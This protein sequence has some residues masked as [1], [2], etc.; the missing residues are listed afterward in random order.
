[1]RR[2]NLSIIIPVKNEEALLEKSI[3]QFRNYFSKQ[4]KI[5]KFEIILCENASEDNTLILCRKICRKLFNVSYIHA[6]KFGTAL[7][8]GILKAIFPYVYINGL[9]NPFKYEDLEQMLSLCAKFDLIYAS[10]THPQS[11]YRINLFR[12]TATLMHSFLSR[13]FFKLPFSD[14]QGTIFM[15]RRKILPL[16]AFCDSSGIFF[17]TQL[18]LQSMYHRLRITSV[19]VHY[20]GLTRRSKF[21]IIV[22]GIKYIF[23][24]F[25][26][27]CKISRIIIQHQY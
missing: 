15:E 17:Q 3:L 5:R 19:P 16:L 8:N 10:K 23:E 18:A 13:I 14:T 11:V 27:K 20:T 12:K 24:V 7:K 21:N 2:I 22:E 25:R 1:M 4:D 6:D 9:D 26:E